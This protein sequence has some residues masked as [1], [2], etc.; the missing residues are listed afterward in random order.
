MHSN[1]LANTQCFVITISR[2]EN[3]QQNNVV[4]KSI[5]PNMIIGK[6]SSQDLKVIKTM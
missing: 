5:S 3:A 1:T 4:Y 6:P 2:L